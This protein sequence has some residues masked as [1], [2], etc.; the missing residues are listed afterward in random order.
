MV[1]D[2]LLVFE[3]WLRARNR[4]DDTVARYIT[5]TKEF[6]AHAGTKK[7]YTA[8]DVTQFIGH[9]SMK[10]K[11]TGQ[12]KK[13]K[14]SGSYLRFNYY[15][16]KTFY[17]AMGIKWEL[18]KDDVPKLDEPYRPY[19]QFENIEK[20]LAHIMA[21]GNERDWLMI[22]VLS[23]TFAR[24]KGAITLKRTD[25]DIYT[26]ALKMPSVK[27]G[28]NV[29]ITLDPETKKVMDHYLLYRTDLLPALFPS[30]R[31]RDNSG[32]LFPTSVNRLVRYYCQAAGVE[33]K[34]MHA[35]RRGMVT[36][37]FEK[38]LRE[39]EI[40]EM[41]DWKSEAMVQKYVQLSPAYAQKAREEVH[42]FYH[43][44]EERPPSRDKKKS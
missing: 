36:F 1:T 35:F 19:M 8:A 2:P 15:T 33:Y 39:R 3:Q 25:Y 22:R 23:L 43:P 37:L 30:L 28:R 17:R 21:H 11:S 34:G 12:K 16:L 24:R 26:G 18:E 41:G 42:P 14:M 31:S 9:L 20:L 32:E 38:G 7:K 10:S 5:A 13:P 29:V 40:F 44:A 4:S 6:I 27:R